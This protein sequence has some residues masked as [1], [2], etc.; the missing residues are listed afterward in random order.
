[1]KDG[2]FEWDDAKAAKNWRAR[3]VSFE[4]ARDVF[5]DISRSNGSIAYMA[6][7]RSDLRL[8]AWSKTACYSLP[9]P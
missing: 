9:T 3:G 1:M 5:K 6:A 7:G 8:S 4:M 2:I